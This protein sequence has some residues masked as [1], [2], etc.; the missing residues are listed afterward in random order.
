MKGPLRM[1]KSSR[2]KIFDDFF[3]E[4]MSEE[5]KLE[6]LKTA[7]EDPSFIKDFTKRIEIEVAFDDYFDQKKGNATFR[8]VVTQKHFRVLVIS[9]LTIAAV[10]LTCFFLITQP[11]SST[12]S[13]EELFA[14]YYKPFDLGI[15]RSTTG[16]RSIAFLYHNYILQDF[17]S[18]S[19]VSI[20]DFDLEPSENLVYIILS[21]AAIENIQFEKS[22]QLLD[23]VNRN[24]DHYLIACYYKALLL[25]KQDRYKEAIPYLQAIIDDSLIFRTESSEILKLLALHGVISTP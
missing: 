11:K 12:L 23:V 5:Q 22:S 2:V 7:S 25:I 14:E 10:F 15:T 17:E 6:F 18:L 13:G 8:K 1:K 3:S 19:K 20:N 4:N 21:I 9:F 16:K 24:E